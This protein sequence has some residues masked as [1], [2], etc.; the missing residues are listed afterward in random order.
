M[1]LLHFDEDAI[2]DKRTRETLV[3]SFKI[4][5]HNDKIMVDIKMETI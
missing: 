3:L 1:G 4:K 5:D 2:H